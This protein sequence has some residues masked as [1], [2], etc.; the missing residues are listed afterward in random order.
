M[1]PDIWRDRTERRGSAT[2]N[3]AT[4]ACHDTE[5]HVVWLGLQKLN[6]KYKNEVRNCRVE[7]TRSTSYVEARQGCHMDPK[8]HVLIAQKCVFKSS[9]TLPKQ[10]SGKPQKSLTSVCLECSLGSSHVLA[11]IMYESRPGEV[12]RANHVF[13]S[14][15]P[16]DCEQTHS[17]QIIQSLHFLA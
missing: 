14:H 16:K 17:S 15:S 4:E 6:T 10:T 2:W 11:D 8:L 13:P 3:R 5:T 9:D 7:T 12:F 1:N